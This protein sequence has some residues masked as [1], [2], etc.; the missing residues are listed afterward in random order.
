MPET[1]QVS[2]EAGDVVSI[3][4][5]LGRTYKATVEFVRGSQKAAIAYADNRDGLRRL[6]VSPVEGEQVTI[7]VP[8]GDVTE[9]IMRPS[10]VRSALASMVKDWDDLTESNQMFW[11]IEAE[12]SIIE[13][14]HFEV[15]AHKNVYGELRYIEGGPR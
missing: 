3:T 12:E 15:A 2:V 6:L 10:V 1:K 7:L 11:C 14:G 8:A 5:G 4:D 9:I 13:T